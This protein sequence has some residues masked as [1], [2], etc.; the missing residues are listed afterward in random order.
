MASLVQRPGGGSYYIQYRVSG[1]LKRKCTGTEI[2]QIAKEKLRVFESAQARGQAADLPTRTPVAD[3]L[4]GYVGHARVA[5]KLK[6]VQTDI[7]YLRDAFGPICEAL[8]ITSRKMSGN[9]KKRPPKPGQDRR[10]TAP[11]IEASHF[12]AITTAQISEFITGRMTSRGLA[13]KTGN[14]I[15]DTLSALFS[16]AM[17]QRGI[18]MPGDKNPAHDC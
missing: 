13:P 18:R 3:V 10:R 2:L 17:S 5:K 9:A 12:E 15:R 6:S 16:W 8:T 11:V 14:R 7:Y 4:A 1:K